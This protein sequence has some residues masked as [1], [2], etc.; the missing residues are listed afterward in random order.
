MSRAE[1]VQD[2]GQ[3]LPQ[4]LVEFQL[5]LLNLRFV[6]RLISTV[7]VAVLRVP[8]AKRLGNGRLEQE[9]NKMGMKKNEKWSREARDTIGTA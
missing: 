6:K 8:E 5:L 4:S 9:T 7:G 3:S 1:A 2:E